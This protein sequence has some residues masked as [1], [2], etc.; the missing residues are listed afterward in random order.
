MAQIYRI[1]VMSSLIGVLVSIGQGCA[2]NR[3]T[4]QL[5]DN[6]DL[7]G[8]RTFYVVKFYRDTGD[9]HLE[10]RISDQLVKM[11]Y[12]ATSG[13]E[14][15]IP[16]GVDAIVSDAAASGTIS[17]SSTPIKPNSAHGW[18]RLSNIVRGAG[19]PPRY[20]YPAVDANTV[21]QWNCNEM[22]GATLADSSGNAN[23]GT[24]SGTYQWTKE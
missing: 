14:N 4:A 2:I 20:P 7:S 12:K 3:A 11:G 1:M 24:F 22:V 6:A 17:A 23:N 19:L 16:A 8:L 13:P 21:A 9:L 5:I 10:K 15:Q 18:L